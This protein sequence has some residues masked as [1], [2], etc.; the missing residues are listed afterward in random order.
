MAA[1]ATQPPQGSS[2]ESV[3]IT[4]AMRSQVLRE[5]YRDEWIVQHAKFLEARNNRDA[6]A[7]RYDSD[8]NQVRPYQIDDANRQ[9]T[10]ARTVDQ[11]VHAVAV[12]YGNRDFGG[13]TAVQS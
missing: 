4:A 5:H 8:P 9:L 6:L 2:D 11:Y 12:A 10:A 1:Q 7:R 3:R 13:F